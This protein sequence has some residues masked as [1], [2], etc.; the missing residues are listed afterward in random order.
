MIAHLTRMGA[1]EPP[2]RSSLKARPARKAEPGE[3]GRLEMMLKACFAIFL[4]ETVVYTIGTIRAAQGKRE[5]RD[6]L[7]EQVAEEGRVEQVVTVHLVAARRPSC[8]VKAAKAAMEES[9][10]AVEPGVMVGRVEQV[11]RGDCYRF[12]STQCQFHFLYQRR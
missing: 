8:L 6:R 3:P 5:A 9:A 7:V 12:A 2:P 1:L 11:E 4:A 10:A